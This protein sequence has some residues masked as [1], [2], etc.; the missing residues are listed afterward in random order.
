M[1][2]TIEEAEKYYID[3]IKDLKISYAKVGPTCLTLLE[4]CTQRNN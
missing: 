1:K 3:H 4:F 2:Q